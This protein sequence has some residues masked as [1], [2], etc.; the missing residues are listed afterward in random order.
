MRSCIVFIDTSISTEFET[1]QQAHVQFN[2]VGM[3]KMLQ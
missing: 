3:Q 1:A 2:D